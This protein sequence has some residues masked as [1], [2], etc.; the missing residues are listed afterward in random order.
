MFKRKEIKADIPLQKRFY[1]VLYLI[2]CNR[3]LDVNIE[4]MQSHF[5]NWSSLTGIP[6]SEF[7]R[8]Y[9]KIKYT[10]SFADYGLQLTTLGYFGI[11]ASQMAMFTNRTLDYRQRRKKTIMGSFL[12][13]DDFKI[14]KQFFRIMCG[15]YKYFDYINLDEDYNLI[16]KNGKELS[17][18]RV[19]ELTGWFIIRIFGDNYNKV[20]PYNT[21]RNTED[22]IK[23]ITHGKAVSWQWNNIKNALSNC[24]QARFIDRKEEHKFLSVALGLKAKDIRDIYHMSHMSV[25]RYRRDF[26]D[27]QLRGL[28]NDADLNTIMIFIRT[29]ME[30][31]KYFCRLKLK[32][33]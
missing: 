15:L 7:L 11:P 4:F 32:E 16:I 19:C 20:Y 6:T 5:E 18:N 14:I 17:Y 1:E 24:R 30:D 12:P 28:A 31:A 9:N 8:L 26:P 3:M 13:D 21:S 23:N 2:I 27:A 22:Y 29:T 25:M 33:E 10:C